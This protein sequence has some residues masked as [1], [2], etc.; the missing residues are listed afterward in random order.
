MSS[1]Q[2]VYSS[3][4]LSQSHHTPRTIIQIQKQDTQ[5]Q[6]ALLM[7]SPSPAP[8]EEPLIRLPTP[9][10]VLSPCFELCTNGI[11][12]YDSCIWLFSRMQRFYA[13]ALITNF[14]HHCP[15]DKE[16]INLPYATV[17]SPQN[18]L[19]KDI[20][21]GSKCIHGCIACFSLPIST[22]GL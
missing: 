21:I 12:Q 5:H 2:R 8:Q 9:P 1:K 11:R 7:P 15:I 10:G 13:S 3:I 4:H 17:C 16:I 19:S 20:C 14:L 18:V 22:S 6:A